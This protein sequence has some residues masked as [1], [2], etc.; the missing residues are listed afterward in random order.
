MKFFLTTITLTLLLTACS[1]QNAFTKFEMDKQE[2]LSVS[3]SQTSKIKFEDK[4]EGVFS[5]IYL[6][7]VDPAS[8]ND[9]EYFYIYLYLKDK[10]EMGGLKFNDAIRTSL[11]LNGQLPIE[12]KQLSSEN[13]FSHLTSVNNEW[14]KYYLVTFKQ[15]VVEKNTKKLNLVFE[16]G[17]LSSEVFT[18]KKKKNL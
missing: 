4:T 11:K 10:E 1:H 16:L 14:Y 3:S 9:N 12:I 13:Q 8:F 7:E 2:E 15:E 6:N 5:A 17:K 18:Y